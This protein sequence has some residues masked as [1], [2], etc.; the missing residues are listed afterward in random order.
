MCEFLADDFQSPIQIIILSV[1]PITKT[2][3]ES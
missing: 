3:R 2:S 1:D